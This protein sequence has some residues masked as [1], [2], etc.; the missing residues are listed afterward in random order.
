MFPHFKKTNKCISQNINNNN[1][2]KA[3]CEVLVQ[4]SSSA[5]ERF[6]LTAMEKNLNFKVTIA[7]DA[8]KE[9]HTVENDSLKLAGANINVQDSEWNSN[10][11]NCSALLCPECECNPQLWHC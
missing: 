7:W 6:L 8:N 3:T 9:Q 5:H 4:T 11:G 10:S 2:N 1:H